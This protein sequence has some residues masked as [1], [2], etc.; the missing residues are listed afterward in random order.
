MT[1]LVVCIMGIV[2]TK[3]MQSFTSTQEFSSRSAA[4]TNRIKGLSEVN[5]DYNENPIKHLSQVNKDYSENPIKRLSEVDQK[6]N[7]ITYFN[8]LERHEI[9]RSADA[10]VHGRFDDSLDVQKDRNFDVELP[11]L[12]AKGLVIPRWGE[13]A[14]QP[15][16]PKYLLGK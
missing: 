16:D 15:Q 7:S 12:V 2:V 14:E 9:A 13:E 8:T 4:L 10:P 3:L 5:K 1:C 6:R 11:R